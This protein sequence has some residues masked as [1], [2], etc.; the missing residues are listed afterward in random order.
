MPSQE[1]R[2][3]NEHHKN[4]G[5]NIRWI[6]DYTEAYKNECERI[7][8]TQKIRYNGE[9]YYSFGIKHQTQRFIEGLFTFND[10]FNENKGYPDVPTYFNIINNYIEI[11]KL[12]IFKENVRINVN[13][14]ITKYK[15]VLLDVEGVY[16]D[17]DKKIGKFGFGQIILVDG[18]LNKLSLNEIM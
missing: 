8:I 4:E 7:K 9:K 13:Y 18:N 17:G 11:C 3:R 5:R 6:L 2:N 16:K 10:R 14:D 1:F 15:L 12:E